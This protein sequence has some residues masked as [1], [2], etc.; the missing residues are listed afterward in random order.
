MNSEPAI[1]PKSTFTPPKVQFLKWVGSK[2]KFA[3][4]MVQF[5]PDEFKIYHEPFLG[6]GSILATLAPDIGYASDIYP[7]LIEIW[8]TLKENPTEVIN[9]YEARYNKFSS[10]D[11]KEQ[12]E[13]IKADF[14][15]R[16]NGPDFLFLT[17]ACWGGVIRFRKLDGYMSTP[18]GWHEPI[19]VASFTLRVNEWHNRIKNV[20]FNCEDYKE[21]FNRASAGDLI[22][23][24]PPYQNSQS[25]LYGSQRFDFSELLEC[26]ANA[27]Q[28]GIYV[29]M[30]I[31]GHSR[32][33]V[34]QENLKIP[35]GI[36][37]REIDINNRISMLLRFKKV[38]QKLTTERDTEKLFLTY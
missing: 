18:V 9:W 26:I 11:R 16:P 10:G 15:N 22:Y 4:E 31:D 21:S 8:Q 35:L 33:G 34:I 3:S 29:A 13:S 36:F 23:C 25:I 20:T 19:N 5:F 2:H 28:R 1:I 27:K 12:Y 14:N 37:E 7:P 32:S 6:S 24:D 30:S 38:G 17:R